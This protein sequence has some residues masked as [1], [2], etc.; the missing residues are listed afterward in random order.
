[1]KLFKSLRLRFFSIGFPIAIGAFLAVIALALWFVAD[2]FKHVERELEAR[3][4]TL[5]LT[6]ELSGVTKLLARLVR[7]FTATGDTRYLTYYYDLAEYRNGKKAAPSA[8]PVQYWENVIA[9]LQEYVKSEDINGKSFS[10]RM[11]EAGFSVA[12]LAALDNA[13]TMS[14][15]LHK[16]EQIAFAATQGLYDPAKQDFVSDGKPNTSFALKLVYGND[17][18]QL[19][20]KL[21][22]EIAKL[23][24]LADERTG[25]SVQ[26]ATDDLF[27]VIVLTAASIGMLLILTLLASLYIHRYVLDPIQEFAP[28]ADRFAA[29]DYQARLIPGNAVAEL[30]TMASA[31]N[32][33]ATA[34]EEDVEHRKEV[35]KELE[36]ARAAAESATRAKSIFLANMSHEIRTPMNAIIGMAY[37]ALRTRLDP[38]QRDYVSKIHDAGKSLLGVI[39]DI[40]DF[41]KIEAG[42]LDLERI[43]FDLQQ[44]VANSLFL[45]RERAMQKEI[46]LLLDMDPALIHEPQLLGDG[47]RLGQVLTNLLSNAVKFTHRGYVEISVR[48]DRTGESEQLRFAVADTGIG[49]SREQIAGL[50]EEFTQADGSTTRQYGGTGLGLAI[51]KRLV[52]LM[53]GEIWVESEVGKGSCFYF[54]AQFG[55]SPDAPETHAERLLRGRALVVDDLPEAR[56][57]LA[58]LLE[59][60]G[61][62]TEQAANGEEALALIEDGLRKKQPFSTAFIDWVM[63]GMDG[64]ALTTAIRSRFGSQ[65]PQLLVVSAYDTEELRQS[66]DRLKIEHFLPKPVLPSALQQIFLGS[67]DG[68][69]HVVAAPSEEPPRLAGMRVLVVE[70]QPINQQL[71]LELLQNMGVHADLAADGEEALAILAA[72]APDH[73]ALVLM[74]LQ[75]PVLDGYETTKRLRAE[76]RYAQLP[77]V[78]MTAHV[79]SEERERCALLGMRGHLGKPID[80]DVLQRMVA[81]YFCVEGEVRSGP[82]ALSAKKA[83]AASGIDARRI[84]QYEPELPQLDGLDIEDGLRHMGGNTRFYRNLLQ[85]FPRDFRRF[86]ERMRELL[87]ERK[88]DEASRLAHSLKGVAANLGARKVA[89]ATALLE[90]AITA[91]TDPT[92]AL[93]HAERQLLPLLN[94]LDDCFAAETPYHQNFAAGDASSIAPPAWRQELLRL[95]KEGDI[96][97]RQLWEQ[98]NEELRGSLPPQTYSQI[99]R[100]LENFEFDTAFSI[101]SRFWS[102]SLQRLV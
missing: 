69:R 85:Q 21:T 80:P 16:S 34:I 102:Q 76:P 38:R 32:K 43:P 88:L 56:L 39:N 58:R 8:D 66:I 72:H 51:C 9:G 54:T 15:Q 71:T 68:E 65:T 92:A 12:E 94:G 70:D 100:A 40:L 45:V 33:M 22:A 101:L 44:T 25:L 96:A 13:L 5:V 75:M 31:F 82:D 47:L 36:Q 78:A 97:A 14:E 59:D 46:E 7:A 63:P 90:K 99:R 79:T 86:T 6:S 62:E 4:K 52:H 83:H 29:G 89:D 93:E 11:R 87:A 30:N 17:Y 1:M 18:A 95:L 20:A 23:T 55:R 73:Y 35:Q 2:S 98:R 48:Q 24:S 77:I 3:K 41:S 26:E 27:R 28:V 49:M 42:R 74:D 91:Q 53:G 57:V 50:F 84:L 64:G 61:M 60:L 37:L 67:R 81:S 10:S 19:Q